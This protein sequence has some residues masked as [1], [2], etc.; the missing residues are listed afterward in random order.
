MEF[1]KAIALDGVE[2]RRGRHADNFYLHHAMTSTLIPFQK[3]VEGYLIPL[4]NRTAL[5][6]LCP[7]LP[8][9]SRYR[10]ARSLRLNMS[11][12]CKF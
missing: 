7:L 8:P 11:F 10:S 1:G 3:D 4:V 2:F 9:Y 6:L 12:D 5:F